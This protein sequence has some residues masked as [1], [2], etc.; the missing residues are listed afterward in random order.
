MEIFFYYGLLL[1]F[2]EVLLQVERRA[3]GERVKIN[4]DVEVLFPNFNSRWLF[5]IIVSQIDVKIK[6][7]SLEVG[8]GCQ[9]HCQKKL[10]ALFRIIFVIVLILIFEKYHQINQ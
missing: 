3:K 5:A 4:V 7:N 2:L 10:V 1:N 6:P 9:L 8:Q